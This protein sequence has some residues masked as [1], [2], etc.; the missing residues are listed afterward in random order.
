MTNIADVLHELD[1]SSRCKMNFDK[2]D[3]AYVRNNTNGCSSI[4]G[5]WMSNNRKNTVKRVNSEWIL[6]FCFFSHFFV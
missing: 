1:I 6:L 3:Y 5:N 4:G 2:I